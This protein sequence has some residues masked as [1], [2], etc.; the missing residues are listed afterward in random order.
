M[1]LICVSL[2][3]EDKYLYT[4][5]K[6]TEVFVVVLVFGLTEGTLPLLNLKDPRD[7]SIPWISI[8]QL[9]LN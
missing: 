2:V 9:S 6:K 8:V 7:R 5:I 4:C 3:I 1:F